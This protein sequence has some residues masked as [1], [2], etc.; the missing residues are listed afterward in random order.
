MVTY[1][2]S[3]VQYCCGDRGTLQTNITGMCGECLQYLGHTGF[4]S[5]HG[6]CAF[7]IYT[8]Q[9]LGCSARELPEAGPG[10][11]A[12]P[13]SKPLRFSF[14]GSPQR[15]R[16]CLACVFCPS[17]VRA[18]QA[19]RCLASSVS[20]GGEF[21]LSPP[22]SQALG[23]LGGSGCALLQCALCLFWGADLWL[24]PS[25]QKST[26]QNPK[27]FWLATGCLLARDC[28]SGAKFA[29]FQLWLPC[30]CFP[31][32]SGGWANPQPSSS[33]LVFAHSFV[34]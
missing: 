6:S 22:W 17:Q 5:A 28:L 11:C 4:A 2:G 10:L 3:L 33:P 12:F 19:T 26:I 24:R 31:V 1:L 23:V 25:W 34:F 14:L 32:S 8:S 7:P 29:S 18:A 15:G 16:L 20:P 27:G 30:S 9:A 21:V 13:R